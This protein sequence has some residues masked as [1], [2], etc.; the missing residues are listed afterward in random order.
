MLGQ[1]LDLGGCQ[2][3]E[4]CAGDV[5]EPGPGRLVF[6]PESDQHHYRQG[7]DALDRQ[8]EHFERSRIG[9][10]GVLEQHQYRF[11]PRQCFQLVKQCRQSQ[12]PLLRRAQC[13]RGI[14]VA[15][16]DRQQGSE[17]RCRFRNG[18]GRQY[19]FELL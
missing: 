4:C 3:V 14:A 13:Q 9:P 16:R 2:P 10:V 6:R 17:E 5:R 15:G 12:S 18:R 1:G 7:T 11:L 19:G 8:I